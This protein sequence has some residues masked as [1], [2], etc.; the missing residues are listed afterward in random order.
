V[1]LPAIRQERSAFVSSLEI[2][3]CRF[4]C[5]TVLV[6]PLL[7]T[8][9]RAAK[10][11]PAVPDSS[12]LGIAPPDSRRCIRAALTQSL[13][14]LC[15]LLYVCRLSAFRIWFMVFSVPA[16]FCRTRARFLLSRFCCGFPMA[17][18]SPATCLLPA[19]HA[20]PPFCCVPA[21][22]LPAHLLQG[23][24]GSACHIL[25][26]WGF[27]SCLPALL[28]HFRL[29]PVLCLPNLLDLYSLHTWDSCCIA[30]NA[31]GFTTSSLTGKGFACCLPAALLPALFT[32]HCTYMPNIC[33]L[34]PA[35]CYHKD[36]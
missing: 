1:S 17:G 19:A 27:F 20:A 32:Y 10:R 31:W 4:C 21:C 16:G 6:S 2:R 25:F 29:L 7:L 5:G 35:A 18:S 13:W 28:P 33:P 11:L 3:F 12:V 23:L 15:C 22:L 36:M 8:C 26:C 24:Y 34:L 14:T 30:E 9:C